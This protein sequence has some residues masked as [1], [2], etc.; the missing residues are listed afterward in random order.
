M[1]IYRLHLAC[2]V[3]TFKVVFFV[4]NVAN[5]PNIIGQSKI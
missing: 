1:Y 5:V 3:N 2:E 4:E